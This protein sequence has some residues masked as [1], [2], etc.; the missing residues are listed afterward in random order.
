VNEKPSSIQSTPASGGAILSIRLS[1]RALDN[2]SGELLW[3]N[4]PPAASVAADLVNASGG[5][6]VVTDGNLFVSKFSSVP[7]AILAAKRIQWAVSGCA[8]AGSADG[9][10][11]TILIQS[12]EEHSAQ[13]AS[14]SPNSFFEHASPGQILLAEATC[15]SLE[16]LPGLRLSPATAGFRELQWR[17]TENAPS[18][19]QDDKALAQFLQQ[20]GL[21]EAMLEESAA[22][23]PVVASV[24]PVAPEKTVTARLPVERTFDPEE[25]GWLS[26]LSEL[27]L[28]LKCVSAAVPLAIV[29]TLF[30]VFF[31][32]KPPAHAADQPATVLPQTQPVQKLTPVDASAASPA[33]ITKTTKPALPKVADARRNPHPAPPEARPASSCGLNSTDIP[34]ELSIADARFQN[35][36]YK[37]A[38]RRYRSVLACQPE[39]G[40]A[41][42]GAERARAALQLQPSSNP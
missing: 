41:V 17:T 35:R 2:P 24:L 33:P 20:H 42:S 31:R 28:W 11:A 15:K 8:E 36:Q 32:A 14:V 1:G 26:R 19:L 40:H 25:D 7:T 13:A 16:N 3:K 34:S 37:E 5:T 22:S 18:R 9:G 10:S 27:P 30:F 4:G 12:V 6:G 39:N 38:E 21:E 23:A 29:A